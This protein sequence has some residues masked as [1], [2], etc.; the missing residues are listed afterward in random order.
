MT[1]FTLKAVRLEFP[2]SFTFEMQIR[3]IGFVNNLLAEFFLS[4]D[5]ETIQHISKNYFNIKFICGKKL[6]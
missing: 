1:Y 2:G 5:F 3:Q 6:S 4:I